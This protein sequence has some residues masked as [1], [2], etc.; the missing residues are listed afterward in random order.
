M[1]VGEWGSGS[2]EGQ[3]G[4]GMEALGPFC[5]GREVR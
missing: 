3:Q 4:G 5:Q 2:S 1:G